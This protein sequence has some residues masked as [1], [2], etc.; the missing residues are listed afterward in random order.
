[1]RE[2]TLGVIARIKVRLAMLEEAR[3]VLNALVEPTR[4]EPGCL[5]Y[6]LLQNKEDPTEFTFVE[7]WENEAALTKHADTEHVRRARARFPELADEPMDLR[8]YTLVH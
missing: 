3:R 5:Q 1:M 7:E 2:D 6:L 4:A 8:K